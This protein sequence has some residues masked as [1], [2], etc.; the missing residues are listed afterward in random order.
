[1]LHF[2]QNMSLGFDVS[3]SIE[4][5]P[6]SISN[7]VRRLVASFVRMSLIIEIV[8]TFSV[9]NV[10]SPFLNLTDCKMTISF[11]FFAFN[12]PQLLS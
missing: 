4:H 2:F 5:K 6:S 12:Q 1:M 9:L 7:L 10:A 8:D 11:F 3:E